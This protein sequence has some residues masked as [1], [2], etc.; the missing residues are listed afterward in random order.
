MKKFLEAQLHVFDSA[1]RE[2]KSGRKSSH[3]MWF[4]FPQLTGL[5]MSE[6]SKYYGLKNLAEAQE[7]LSHPLLG[8]RLLEIS[9]ALLELCGNDATQIFGNPDDLKLKSSMTL[10]AAT[11][12]ADP[13]FLQVIHKFF[14][15]ERDERTIR[16]LNQR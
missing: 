1:L 2:I 8:Q 16:L 3:W 4:I 6:T 5:G 12:D 14:K 7:Y 13:V 11:Q 10:F 9:R 15:G